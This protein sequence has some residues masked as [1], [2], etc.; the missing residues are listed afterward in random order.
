MQYQLPARSGMTPSK[1]I[2][3]VAPAILIFVGFLGYV[4]A[5]NGARPIRLTKTSDS[6]FPMKTIF[7]GLDR[8]LS[9]GVSVPFYDNGEKVN[10]PGQPTEPPPDLD[11]TLER[12]RRIAPV[13]PQ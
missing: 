10:R 1:R 5:V 9:S 3:A 8:I 13:K 11:Q 12:W 6:K 4:A 2:R 7:W